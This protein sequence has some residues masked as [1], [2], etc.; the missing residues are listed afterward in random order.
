MHKA[1]CGVGAERDVDWQG[2]PRRP[3]GKLRALEEPERRGTP[4]S[5]ADSFSYQACMSIVNQ[6]QPPDPKRSV[7]SGRVR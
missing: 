6:V 1:E 7:Q 2:R 5:E 4:R 3:G